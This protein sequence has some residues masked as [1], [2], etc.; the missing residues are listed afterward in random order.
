[1]LRI[2]RL[3]IMTVVG[4]S[5]FAA[6]AETLRQAE[7]LQQQLESSDATF[8]VG[9]AMRRGDPHRGAIVFHRSA[10]ACVAC[11]S[12]G[13][14]KSPLGPNLAEIGSETKP[15]YLVDALLRPSKDIRKGFETH[16]LITADG[17]VISGMIVTQN[18]DTM[19]I[20]AADNLTENVILQRDEIDQTRATSTSMMPEGLIASVRDQR[21][22]YDLLRYVID[23]TKGG[24]AAAKSL[25]PSEE[26]LAVKDDSVNLDHAGIIKSLKRK[27]FEAGEAIYHGYCFNC[28]GRDGNTP[29]L[30][31]ARAFGTQPM[32]FGADPYRMFMTLTK[33][34]GLMAPMSHLTPKERYQVVH[35]IR[36][37]FMQNSNPDFFEV[38][39]NYLATLPRGNK[40]G[41]EIENVQR[42]FGPALGSQLRR[43]FPSVLS[44]K[45]G[46]ATIAYD[47]HTM[48][49]ADLWSGGFL[50]LSET[51]HVRPRGEGTADPD[52]VSHQATARL[53]VGTRRQLGLLA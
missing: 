20:R 18:D 13:Q 42:D 28:H 50:D 35:Y 5:A 22:F 24:Q 34:N 12:S 6:K 39:K 49:Q 33:G 29:S 17:K 47:L 4:F 37:Q 9:E 25:Q 45:L 53:A 14:E 52:G 46:D 23:V 38:N 7:P 51:Q 36:E 16:S 32:K 2:L 30:P 27:D 10:A 44:I 41:T 48:N 40:D 3:S 8:L 1:M 31:T 26:E 19:T 11:H 43:D 21:E 15:E